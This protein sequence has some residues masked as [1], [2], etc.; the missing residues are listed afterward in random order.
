MISILHVFCTIN[1][2]YI[3]ICYRKNSKKTNI[4]THTIDNM[5]AIC[6][7]CFNCKFTEVAAGCLTHSCADS[8]WDTQCILLFTG[9]WVHFY[10]R[11]DMIMC[12]VIY[13]LSDRTAS[14]VHFLLFL[15]LKK[16]NK[17]Y[18]SY[19]RIQTLKLCILFTHTTDVTSNKAQHNIFNVKNLDTCEGCLLIDIVCQRA[20]NSKL[21][22]YAET[23]P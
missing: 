1:V 12:D 19:W 10:S 2:D 16:E 21:Y 15:L 17:N 18:S 7:Y 4:S 13:K 23:T 3:C 9:L 20:D 11:R 5:P 14:A 8:D 6:T 22:A